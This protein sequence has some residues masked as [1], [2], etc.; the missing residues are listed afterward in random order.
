MLIYS[1]AEVSRGS[2]LLRQC[3]LHARKFAIDLGH[4]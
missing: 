3:G 4:R 1:A 2:T